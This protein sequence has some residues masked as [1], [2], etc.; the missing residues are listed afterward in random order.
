M[1]EIDDESLE[2]LVEVINSR[3]DISSDELREKLS[4]EIKNDSVIKSLISRLGGDDELLRRELIE[5]ELAN[6]TESRH[7]SLQSTSGVL[8]SDHICEYANEFQ[9]IE[10][11][12]TDQLK[13]A[14]YE[15]TVGDK[16]SI[17]GELYDLSDEYG[18]NEITIP[19][20]EVAVI[21][22]YEKINMPRFLI[23]RWNI[24]VKLAY[25]GLLWVG[26]PQV[27]P[28]YVGHLYCPIYNLS[29]APVTISYRDTIAVMDFAKTTPFENSVTDYKPVEY[30]RPPSKVLFE[31]YNPDQ[32]ISALSENLRKRL[33][34][35]ES[36]LEVYSKRFI[37]ISGALVTALAVLFAALGIILTPSFIS[38]GGTV[39]LAGPN[40]YTLFLSV[41][42]ILISIISVILSIR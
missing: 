21:K 41:C 17:E 31:E 29:D 28:G 23:A 6:M 39:S 22:T 2:E 25:K 14:A 33:D 1:T 11:F 7:D 24:K 27:D 9:L 38:S 12:E 42:A 26:G 8:L 34:Q 36:E 30:D 10:P 5:R 4:N 3:E 19:P 20:F 13:P 16:Y 18:D 35:L 40:S 15:L 32:L 37:Q